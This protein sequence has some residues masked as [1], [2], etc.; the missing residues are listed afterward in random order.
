[1]AKEVLVGHASLPSTKAID[2]V[3]S[4]RSLVLARNIPHDLEYSTN[5]RAERSMER[6]YS[7]RDS[8]A[9][10]TVSDDRLL[11]VGTGTLHRISPG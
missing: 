8:G 4:S 10:G 5:C 1:M 6:C 9:V 11:L 7:S 3:M 2:L